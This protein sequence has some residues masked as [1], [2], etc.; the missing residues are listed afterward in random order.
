MRFSP[1]TADEIVADS[2][3]PAGEYPFE[4]LAAQDKLS[5]AGNEMIEL[6]L[7]VYSQDGDQTH[8]FDYLLEKIAYKLRH[9]AEAVGLLDKYEK[10]EFSA[11]DCEG[12]NG[13]CKL[14][15]D[16][17]N[18]NYP[19]KNTVRDYVVKEASTAVSAKPAPINPARPAMT[20]AHK[21]SMAA[22]APVPAGSFDDD[23][24]F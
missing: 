24:P 22:Q 12:K 21:A 15:I 14:A 5:K 8:V 3:L 20:L 17:S 1:K 6:K 10:G 7:A 13:Y 11:F 9:F 23:I 16:S 4:V 18:P 19:P 2:L